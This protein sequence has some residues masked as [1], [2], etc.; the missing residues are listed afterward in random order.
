MLCKAQT[1]LFAAIERGRP[2]IALHSRSSLRYDRPQ[3]W[4]KYESAITPLGLLLTLGSAPPSY[5]RFDLFVDICASDLLFSTI[6]QGGFSYL[7]P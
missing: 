4:A 5:H 1:S 3:E 2:S 6:C 7:L